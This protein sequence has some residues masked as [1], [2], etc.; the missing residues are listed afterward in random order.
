MCD[1]ISVLCRGCKNRFDRFLTAWHLA[2][3]RNF[4]VYK[5]RAGRY[6]FR[7]VKIKRRGAKVQHE[8][9]YAREVVYVHN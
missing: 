2:R 5:A 1:A 4:M 3:E 6:I 9:K 7:G 8:F